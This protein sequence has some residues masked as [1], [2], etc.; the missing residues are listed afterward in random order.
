MFS[1]NSWIRKRDTAVLGS[2]LIFAKYNDKETIK[3]MILM[4][5][6]LLFLANVKSISNS[7]ICFR[8]LIPKHAAIKSMKQINA[9]ILNLAVKNL[10]NF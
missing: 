8:K 3:K 2:R 10:T 9:V 7:G 5:K 1:N 6:T 4:V